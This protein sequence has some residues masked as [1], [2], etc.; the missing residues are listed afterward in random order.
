MNLLFLDSNKASNNVFTLDNRIQGQYQLLTFTTTNN[1]YNVT[2]NNNKIY[3]NE[4]GS[5]KTTTLTNGYYD[6]TDFKTE[7]STQLNSSASGTI[8]VTLDDNTRKFTITDTLNFYFTFATNTTNSARKLLG[9]N[10]S[11]GTNATSQTSDTPCDL[12]SC[13]NIFLTINEDNHRNIRGIDFFNSSFVINSTGDFGET[14]R[15]IN[16]DNFNQ[17]IK[18]R[19]TKKLT[20]SFHDSNNNSVDLNSEYQIILSKIS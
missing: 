3:W 1:M 5:N 15:Y 20:V 17:F 6:S 19:D 11:D 14:L 12:N 18:F 13:K 2:A 4:N 16:V 8:T 9:F 10:A 7:L